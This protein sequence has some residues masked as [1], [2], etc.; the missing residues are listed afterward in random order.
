M[1]RAAKMI[2]WTGALSLLGFGAY[3]GAGSLFRG[4]LETAC[5][6]GAAPDATSSDLAARHAIC[7]CIGDMAQSELS[8]RQREA[9]TLWYRRDRGAFDALVADMNPADA[10]AFLAFQNAVL[11]R[12]VDNG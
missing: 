4:E 10:D 7:A 6:D 3:L 2:F 5:R 8:N 1:R 12:C 9:A 11:A